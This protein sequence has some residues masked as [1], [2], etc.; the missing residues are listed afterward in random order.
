MQAL[1]PDPPTNHLILHPILFQASRHDG[2]EGVRSI[3]RF[4]DPRSRFRYIRTKTLLPPLKLFLT[5]HKF[6]T[7]SEP[8]DPI[9]VENA[10]KDALE[11]GYRHI[12]CAPVY[13]NEAAVGRGL[14]ASGIPREQIFVRTLS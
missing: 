5:A 10:V 3:I 4:P 6:S 11:I 7:T 14:K 9:E 8:P 2:K 13:Q 1:K 12:D